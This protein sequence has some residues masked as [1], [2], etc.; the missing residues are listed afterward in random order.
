MGGS[1]LLTMKCSVSTR[2]IYFYVIYR[3]V[4]ALGNGVF[5]NTATKTSV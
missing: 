4:K 3:F 5:V 1:S 2:H